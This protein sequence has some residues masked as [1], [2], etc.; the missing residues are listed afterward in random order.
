MLEHKAKTVKTMSQQSPKM[1]YRIIGMCFVAA[2]IV[3]VFNYFLINAFANENSNELTQQQQQVANEMVTLIKEIS[4]TRAKHYGHVKRFNQ[5]K[6]LGCVQAK[7][8]VEEDIAPQLKLGLFSTEKTYPAYIRFASASKMDDTKKDLRGMSIKVMNTEHPVIWGTF[9]EQDFIL[10]NAPSLF[11]KNSEEFLD[12]IRAINDDKLWW[13]FVNPF[14]SHFR[15]LWAILQAR[16]HHSSPLD[17]RYWSATPYQLGSGA[18]NA[19]KYT[20]KP[21]SNYSSELPDELYN[22]YLHDAMKSHLSNQ[23]ACFEFMVQSRIP[24]EN[25]PIDNAAVVW[26]E[27][28][29]PFVKVATILIEPQIFHQAN[30]IKHC[31][32]IAFNPWQSMAEHKP[33]GEMNK[34]RKEVYKQLAA[35]RQMQNHGTNSFVKKGGKNYE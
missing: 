4:L 30:Q 8:I 17:I 28:S 22:G 25:M 19:V 33:L 15:S 27:E 5:V 16:D 20:A 13:F 10:N 35:F 24:N 21:C 23:S 14:N 6:T 3:F 7:F 9:G 1:L 31:E 2:L 29:A 11:V 26:S 18:E 34:V 12:F 32:D